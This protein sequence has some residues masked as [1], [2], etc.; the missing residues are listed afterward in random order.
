MDNASPCNAGR[1]TSRQP[2]TSA[3]DSDHKVPDSRGAADALGAKAV[4]CTFHGRLQPSQSV[5]LWTHRHHASSASN[6]GTLYT[7]SADL[8][9]RIHRKLR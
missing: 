8:P 6:R 7:P 5:N 9:K 2:P 4:P 3:T 1:L